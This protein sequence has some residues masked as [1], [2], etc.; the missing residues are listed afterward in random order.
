[1][2]LPQL[3]SSP[4]YSM[5]IPSS[6]VDVKFRPYL[7][8][9]E[10]VLL[11]ALE[12]Q[13]VKTALGAVV[14]T[15]TSCV[16]GKIQ[17]EDLTTFDVEYMFTQIRSKSSGETSE[18]LL[19]CSGCGHQNEIS[20]PLDQLCV[21]VPKAN[22]FI[23]LTGDISLE[24]K[25]PSYAEI[26]QYDIENI[27]KSSSVFDL[28]ASCIKSIITEEERIDSRECSKEQ[29]VEFLESMTTQQFKGISDFMAA[30]PKLQ[31]DVE[32]KCSECEEHNKQTIEGMQN[33]F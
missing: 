6:Q 19:S 31:H 8:K 22:S 7:V 13:D 24:L 2:S 23:E 5:T 4:K 26:I 16:E 9:E 12:T 15:I 1:M 14:D 11:M 17:P 10:K 20:I 33:F 3:N 29:L 21:D 28:A 27:D 25:Y 18:V 32:F 30:I